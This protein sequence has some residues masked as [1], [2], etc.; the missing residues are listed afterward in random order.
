[1][2][3]LALGLFAG[4]VVSHHDELEQVGGILAQ[5]NPT[6]LVLALLAQI[7]FYVL[8]AVMFYQIVSLWISLSFR[9]IFIFTLASNSFN[10]LVPS[11]GLSG[12]L[13]FISQARDKGIDPGLSLCSNALFYLMDYLSFVV[14]V[15]WG[16]YIF[17]QTSALGRA[18]DFA[19]IVFSLLIIALF[20][21]AALG[22]KYPQTL[23]KWLQWTARRLPWGRSQITGWLTTWHESWHLLHDH[24]GRVWRSLGLTFLV[25]LAMQMCDV[26]IL[27][28]CCAS[29]HAKLPPLKAIAAFGLSSVIS[30]A[31]MVP[32]GIGIYESSLTW[33]L[34]QLGVSF[35][36]ALTIALLYRMVTYWFAMLPGLLVIPRG[37]GKR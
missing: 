35:A 26:L 30:L 13:V 6:Y 7:V 1:L 2:L 27:W 28:L 37:E 36:L 16:L 11:G 31:S 22:L 34:H 25:G 15:W 14:I 17:N 18:G 3:I 12:L 5:A 9:D 24:G 33:M 20:L 23:G 10:K 29:L 21:V 4:L 19:I 8:Q 32:Q